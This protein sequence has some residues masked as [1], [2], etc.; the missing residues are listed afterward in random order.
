MTG[1][2]RFP[3]FYILGAP[4]A[5]TSSLAQYLDER[6]DV[7][8]SKPK[9]PRYFAEDFGDRPIA[10]D[11]IYLDLFKDAPESALLGE[12]TTDY[13]VSTVAVDRI[14]AVRP[15]AKLIAML[16]NPVEIV[17]AMHAQERKN[18]YETI[19]EPD[20]AWAAIE[21]RKAGRNLPSLCQEPKR[22]FY[23]D[24]CL[25][26]EQIQRIKGKVGANQLKIIFME[27]FAKRTAEIYQ[28][29]L[30]F[31][32]LPADGRTEFAVHNSR[33]HIKHPGLIQLWK[34]GKTVKDR[35]GLKTE[36]G[37]LHKVQ[38]AGLSTTPIAE[39]RDMERFRQTLSQHFEADIR[40]LGELT[41]RD[42]STWLDH[43]SAGGR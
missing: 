36:F 7:F 6:D 18:G 15:D 26:G 23:D 5:G 41:G 34:L 21:T 10:D 29:T 31:L 24:R 2:R 33:H 22:L 25:L 43:P 16:R 30:D 1:S 12:G 4:K 20:E 9:E 13:L 8:I 39:K 27:D 19:A 3:D 17:F 42:L 28:E 37:L 35:L 32:G 14:L 11:Q 40:L 38:Q